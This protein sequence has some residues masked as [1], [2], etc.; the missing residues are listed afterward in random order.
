MLQSTFVA[1]MSPFRRSSTL[2]KSNI[3]FMQ[4]IKRDSSSNR[5]NSYRRRPEAPTTGNGDET[6]SLRANTRDE[7]DV[8]TL[9]VLTPRVN[10]FR[11]HCDHFIVTVTSICKERSGHKSSTNPPK[12]NEPN[13]ITIISTGSFFRRGWKKVSI[14]CLWVQP[15]SCRR[16]KRLAVVAEPRLQLF[17]SRSKNQEVHFSP[18]SNRKSWN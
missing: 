8:D 10:R 5:E 14:K 4:F 7:S 13:A 17:S 3:I 2:Q 18:I 1:S 12:R 11:S 9:E 16:Q 6:T 15:S